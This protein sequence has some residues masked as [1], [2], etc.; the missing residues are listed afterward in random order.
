MKYRNTTE[1]QE[2]TREKYWNTLDFITI[3]IH[4]L[5]SQKNK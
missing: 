1:M 3:D 2:Y 4:V 5:C